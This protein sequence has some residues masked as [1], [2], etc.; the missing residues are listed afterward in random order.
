LAGVAWRQKGQPTYKKTIKK[1]IYKRCRVVTEARKNKYT[2]TRIP[3][4]LTYTHTQTHTQTCMQTDRHT[5][6]ERDT[7]TFELGT[8]NIHIHTLTYRQTG[9]LTHTMCVL[10]TYNI[11]IRTRSHTHTHTHTQTHE[12]THTHTHTHVHVLPAGSEER[13]PNQ[14][15][16]RL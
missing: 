3:H 16:H 14:D 7:H 12:H 8:Y 2:H 6:R 4:T 1:Y 13:A 15:K 11:R 5:D 9:R 10:G